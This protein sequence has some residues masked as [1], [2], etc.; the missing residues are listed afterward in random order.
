M[1]RRPRSEG[2]DIR[3]LSAE[4][5]E[6]PEP[7]TFAR[8]AELLHDQG[9]LVEARSMC[10][11]CI[12][13]HPAYMPVRT[14]MA[15]I[16]E[17][18][19]D[20]ERAEKELALVVGAQPHNRVARVALAELLLR[21]DSVAKAKEHLEYAL[22]LAPGDQEARRMLAQASGRDAARS[23]EIE[24]PTAAPQPGPT[25]RAAS[26]VDRALGQVSDTEGVRAAVLVDHNGLPI[27]AAG[28]HGESPDALAV[29]LHEAW[30]L[31]HT[32]V[33][34][35]EL[36]TLRIATV[37]GEKHTFVVAPCGP[38]LLAAA[39][40]HKARLGLVHLQ[41]EAARNLLVAL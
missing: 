15:R 34:R 8:L 5:R 10:G 14:I 24:A 12:A 7:V 17:A 19:G 33:V 32:Y 18:E 26:T 36:G 37:F 39:M 23:A 28:A 1:P 27:G 6:S 30:Q 13:R 11:Q 21:R 29:V 31:A 40:T 20:V 25:S 22:F 4:L 41:M 35:M 38:G 2:D 3:R 16:C 9:R